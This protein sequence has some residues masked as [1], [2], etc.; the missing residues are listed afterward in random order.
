VSTIK[1]AITVTPIAF[2]T[3][4]LGTMNGV[5]LQVTSQQ[6]QS[7]VASIAIISFMSVYVFVFGLNIYIYYA[8][9]ADTNVF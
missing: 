7:K 4:F 8:C 1:E 2:I 6:Q 5:S 9:P 3:C